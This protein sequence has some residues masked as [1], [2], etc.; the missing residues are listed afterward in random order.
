MHGPPF[1]PVIT[2]PSTTL[3]CQREIRFLL[4]VPECSVH[5]IDI[6]GTSGRL[7]VGV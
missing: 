6:C 5:Y 7:A 2:A 1:V 4:P 3:A